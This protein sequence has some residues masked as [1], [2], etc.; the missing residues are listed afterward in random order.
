MF[1]G[2]IIPHGEK[3]KRLEALE[4]EIK[5]GR[6]DK[7][8]IPYLEE[9]NLHNVMTTG[10]C[11]GHGE[12][13]SWDPLLRRAHVS[14]RSGY[15]IE[16]TV[17]N[18]IKPMLQEFLWLSEYA[19]NSEIIVDRD[20]KTQYRLLLDNVGWKIQVEYFIKSLNEIISG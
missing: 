13:C 5:S 15:S 17:E 9:I 19:I 16:D 20:E 18:L 7:E 12:D 11:T 1:N 8:F 2:N 10:C 14:F 6:V 4:R 3:V